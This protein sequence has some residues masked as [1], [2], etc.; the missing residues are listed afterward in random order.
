MPVA[1]KKID[2]KKKSSDVVHGSRGLSPWLADSIW[3]WNNVEYYGGN[4]AAAIQI[5]L[6]RA[7]RENKNTLTIFFPLQFSIPHKAPLLGHVFSAQAIMS[8]NS[9]TD[10]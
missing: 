2:L 3:T 5:M 1:K 6:G 9:P 7:Q 8:K 10:P 4:P